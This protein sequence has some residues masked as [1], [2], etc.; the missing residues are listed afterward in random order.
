LSVSRDAAT[1]L[2]VSRDAATLLSVSR[3][4][5]TLLS[6]SRDAATLCIHVPSRLQ[7]GEAVTDRCIGR[8]RCR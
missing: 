4:A 6:V 2:S 7:G 3:D 1:L 8:D 5:A